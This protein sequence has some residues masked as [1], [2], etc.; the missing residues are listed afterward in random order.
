MEW[1][2][3]KT[4]SGGRLERYGETGGRNRRRRRVIEEIVISPR[5]TN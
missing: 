5:R 2:V 1:F 4:N 3:W